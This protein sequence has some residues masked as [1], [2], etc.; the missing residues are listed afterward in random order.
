MRDQVSQVKQKIDGVGLRYEASHTTV[1]HSLG[2]IITHMR[3]MSLHIGRPFGTLS[4]QII[5]RAK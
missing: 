4:S 2:V 1:S 5:G 3:L